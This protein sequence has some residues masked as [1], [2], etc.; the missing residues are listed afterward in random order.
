M[1]VDDEEDMLLILSKPV[2]WCRSM[3]VTADDDM[4]GTLE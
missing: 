4:K 1:A 3:D 2:T